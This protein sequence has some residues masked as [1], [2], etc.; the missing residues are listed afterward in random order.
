MK[1]TVSTY[2]IKTFTS[3]L[4]Y[5]TKL[6]NDIKHFA[7]LDKCIS[8]DEEDNE[9]IDFI[10]Y[11]INFKFYYKD[12]EISI[13]RERIGESHYIQSRGE[14]GNYEE[15]ELN[16][17]SEELS[18]DDKIELMKNFILKSKDEYSDYRKHKTVDD[19]LFLWSF[20]DGFWESIKRIKK[21]NINTVILDKEVKNEVNKC[22]DNYDNKEL[23]ERLNKLGINLKMNLILSGLP[24][25]GKSSL[26]FAI[27]SK[28]N[29]DISTIDFNNRE[30]TDHS[31]I[32][33]T[34]KIPKNSIFVLEDIDAL[35]ISRNKS[36]EN[37]VSFSCILNFLDGIYS[38]E[39]LITII[40][41]NH[42]DKLDKAIIRPMRIDNIIHFTHCSKYQYN[43]IFKLIFP[44]KTE[45][46]SEF[47]KLI[48]NKKFTTSILQK[49]LIKFI[50]NPEKIIENLKLFDEYIAST[51]DKESNMFI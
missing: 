47:Y 30:L 14:S 36:D 50:F 27:A 38:K 45:I 19:K 24:G 34:N 10:A 29:K 15:I 48:K 7:Y 5:S 31:F 44:D 28:L 40:T 41:T 32:C 8:Y 11:D 25:T 3:V 42:L 13:K 46:G 9:L 26:M 49:Y 2:D 20:S 51:T 17:I 23:K 43:E 22:I 35:Y 39:D 21:R 18:D 12:V 6:K 1:I 16:I 37:R 33:A 4:W